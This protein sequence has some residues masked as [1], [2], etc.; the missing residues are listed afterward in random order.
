MKYRY[1]DDL[2]QVEKDYLADKAFYEIFEKMKKHYPPMQAFKIAQKE[3][4]NDKFAPITYKYIKFKKSVQEIRQNLGLS[5]TF[6][7]KHAK[8]KHYSRQLSF[9]FGTFKTSCCQYF[10]TFN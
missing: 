1:Y 5:L 7:K 3:K 6:C 2:S 10:K 4:Y 9:D 8:K